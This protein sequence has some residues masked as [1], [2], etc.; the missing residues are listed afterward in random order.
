M[1]DESPPQL[2]IAIADPRWSRLLPDPEQRFGAALRQALERAGLP[3]R[4]RVIVEV[5]LTDDR[6]VHALNARY[7]GRDAPT[8]VLSFPQF[9]PDELSRLAADGPP[10]PLGDIVLAYETVERDARALKRAPADHALHLFVHG[11]LHLLGHDHEEETAAARM[12]R[13]EAEILAS[14]G[15]ADPYA[16][17]EV[18][19]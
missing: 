15:I 16:E 2:S 9:A 8:D 11:V 7:R 10:V 6:A 14:F 17:Q 4:R 5:T 3:A 13:L 18:E 1:D 19:P 12:E